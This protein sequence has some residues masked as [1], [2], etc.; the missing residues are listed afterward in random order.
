MKNIY[1]AVGWNMAFCG[2]DVSHVMTK[3]QWPLAARDEASVQ[4]VVRGA[5]R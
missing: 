2:S 4:A 5:W 3:N 1:N